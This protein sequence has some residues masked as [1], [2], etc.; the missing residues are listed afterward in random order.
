MDELQGI[1]YVFMENSSSI[2]NRGLEDIEKEFNKR[3]FKLKWTIMNAK[4]YGALHSRNRWFCIAYKTKT[5]PHI[6]IM[7]T[8]ALKTKFNRP[9]V[10]KR[11]MKHIKRCMMLGN[12]V[13]PHIVA[14]AWNMLNGF[15][16]EEKHHRY[17]EPTIKYW[18]GDS[19]YEK[20][21]WAT[22]TFQGW[23]QH[24]TLTDRA[25]RNLLDQIM[26]MDLVEF[27]EGIARHLRGKSYSVNP[28]FVEYLMGYPVNWTYFV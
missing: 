1:K 20:T 24:K 15:K 6:R 17:L 19:K 10:V 5:L 4:D 14:L 23:Y 28:L 21:L 3:G 16:I 7:N 22:P 27:D 2:V 8:L 12:S 25:S 9:L 18:Q 26:Y 11:D 13:V